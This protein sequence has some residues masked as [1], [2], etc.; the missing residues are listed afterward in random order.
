[1]LSWKLREATDGI[2]RFQNVS[3]IFG[4]WLLEMWS[5]NCRFSGTK[6]ACRKRAFKTTFTL[7]IAGWFGWWVNNMHVSDSQS[8]WDGTRLNKRYELRAG[9]TR[10][11]LWKRRI[12]CVLIVCSLCGWMEISE[13][14]LNYA[15]RLWNELISTKGFRSVRSGTSIC[16]CKFSSV[17]RHFRNE[18]NKQPESKIKTKTKLVQQSIL[19]IRRKLIWNSIGTSRRWEPKLFANWF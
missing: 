10:P 19:I 16:W 6:R 13:S 17:Q 18:I 2:R 15:L 1:M 12:K 14:F 4:C 5:M 8:D 11:S 9:K 3:Q 7:Y